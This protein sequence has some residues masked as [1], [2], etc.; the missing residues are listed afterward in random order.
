[1]AAAGGILVLLVLLI[2]VGGGL[3]LYVLVR[4]EHSSR[5]VTDRNRAEQVARRDRRDDREVK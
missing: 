1:M 2:S 4:A 3:L 5:E